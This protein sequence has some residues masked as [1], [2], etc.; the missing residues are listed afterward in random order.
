MFIAVRLAW[1]AFGV[2]EVTKHGAVVAKAAL[3]IEKQ[4]ERVG[5]WVGERVGAG[6]CDA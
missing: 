3:R 1:S 6:G 4:Q 5:K 2:W